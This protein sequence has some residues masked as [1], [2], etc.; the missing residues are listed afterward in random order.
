LNQAIFREYDIRGTVGRDLTPESV[1]RLGWAIGAFYHRR[2]CSTMAIGRDARPSSEELLRQLVQG[3]VGSGLQVVDIGLCPT[4][5]LYFASA[6]FGSD[7][8]VMITGSHNPPEYNGFKLL[9]RQLPVYGA[10]VGEIGRS[11]LQEER[12]EGRS[13]ELEHHPILDEYCAA[14]LER[15]T[16]VTRPIRVV[17]D[18]GN[19]TGGLVAERVYSALGCR[20]V[21]LYC[22]VDGQFPNHHPDP[23]V[24]ENLSDLIDRVKGEHADLGIAFDGDADRLGAV[25]ETGAI[26][27]GDDLLTLFAREVLK[28][29]PGTPVIGDVKCSDRLFEEIRALGGVPIMW[30]SGHSLIKAKMRETEALLAGEWSAHFCFADRFFGFDDGIYAGGRLIEICA[31]AESGISKQLEGRERYPTPEFRIPCEDECKFEVVRTLS[32]FFSAR[33]DTIRLD[34]VRVNFD[35]GWALV[36][37][38]NT[39]PVL[40]TRFEGRTPEHRDEIRARVE[41]KLTEVINSL[42]SGDAGCTT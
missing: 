7:C 26:L 21:A 37:A 40:V 12:L 10:E 36:R 29:H 15:L 14:L 11:A 34:G 35:G 8:A 28:R 3:L 16:P 17:V 1:E 33:Y 39:Q 20:I 25:D 4:P 22:D 38:S 31:Q 27:W 32:E 5:A 24:A 9:L 13:G 6:H 18:A 2:N 30:K 41:G 23:T 42:K 19:G